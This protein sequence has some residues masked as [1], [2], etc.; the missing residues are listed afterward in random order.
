M[1]FKEAQ[2]DMRLAYLNGG[3]GVLASGIIWLAT[4]IIS[5]YLSSDSSILVFFF[6]GMF[7][8]PLA[9]LI[10]KLFKR[11]GQHHKE[12]PLAKSALE[13]TVILFAGLFIAY[14]IYQTNENFFYPIML[15]VIGV[16]YLAFQTLYGLRAYWFLG[17]ALMIAGVLYLIFQQ[18]FYIPI[19]TG[20]LIEL[21]FSALIMRSQKAES[22]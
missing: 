22:T 1:T 20:G 18:Q 12:N 21:I 8:F 6:G 5:I 3:P 13:N 15:M 4:A 9:I 2:E 17:L 14:V 7:I 19:L 10:S 16:R 11:S